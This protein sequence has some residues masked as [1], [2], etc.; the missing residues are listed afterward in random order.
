M[1]KQFGGFEDVVTGVIKF[2]IKSWWYAWEQLEG[3]HKSHVT[4]SVLRHGLWTNRCWQVSVWSSETRCWADGVRWC[5]AGSPRGPA[6]SGLWWWWIVLNLACW[7]S[8]THSQC[9]TGPVAPSHGQELL[10]ALIHHPIRLQHTHTQTDT[11]SSTNRPHLLQICPIHHVLPE[12]TKP[13][14]QG[15]IWPQISHGLKEQSAHEQTVITFQECRMC[16]LFH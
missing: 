6:M 5:R 16:V 3:S 2:H 10:M 11:H 8:H 1:W 12:L 14:G 13:E 15:Q 4:L 9:M 7:H